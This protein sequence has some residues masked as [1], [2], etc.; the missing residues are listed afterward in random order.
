MGED[1]TGK[2]ALSRPE[3]Q[4]VV[5][6]RVGG[7]WMLWPTI[8]NSVNDAIDE[9]KK[10]S[11]E[12]EAGLFVVAHVHTCAAI[13]WEFAEQN[14]HSMDVL[15]VRK[16]TVLLPPPDDDGKDVVN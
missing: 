3:V 15:V 11:T 6:A 13:L 7:G 2:K 14:P 1:P 4:Y 10:C 12:W 8:T 5:F 16:D 9:M